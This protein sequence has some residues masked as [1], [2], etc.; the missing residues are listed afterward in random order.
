VPV[1]YHFGAK[2]KTLPPAAIDK[3]RA[4]HPQG[5]FHVYDADH[6]FN[7]DQ[8]A[9][10]DAA[11]AKLARER[12]LAFFATHLAEALDDEQPLD[13]WGDA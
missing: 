9:S 3:I 12:T 5:E 10:Y 4:A 1:Q 2:D 7:C 11:A 8:R 13:N 6:G